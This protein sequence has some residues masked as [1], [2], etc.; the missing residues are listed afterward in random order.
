MYTGGRLA[1]NV[2]EADH[3]ALMKVSHLSRDESATEKL[4]KS[5]C[6]TQSTII[7][8]VLL[9][10]VADVA[11]VA[12]IEKFLLLLSSHNPSC[13]QRMSCMT[14]S[15]RT[16]MKTR[17]TICHAGTRN[18]SAGPFCGCTGFSVIGRISSERSRE[19][20]RKLYVSE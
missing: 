8:F 16:F 13:S 5:C 10:G 7:A 3:K 14:S 18:P 12:S 6:F 2:Q 15:F 17:N 20:L 1:R 11:P 9:P 4:T 19:S